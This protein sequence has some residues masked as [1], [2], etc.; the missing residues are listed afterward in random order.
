M[1]GLSDEQKLAIV[2]DAI[3]RTANAYKDYMH[4]LVIRDSNAEALRDKY[5]QASRDEWESIRLLDIDLNK[6]RELRGWEPLP[7]QPPN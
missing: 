2:D 3:D 4:A 1:N 5:Q 7:E 6:V